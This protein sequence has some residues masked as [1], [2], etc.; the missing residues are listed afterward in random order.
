MYIY[1]YTYVYVYVCIKIFTSYSGEKITPLEAIHAL[2]HK[3][4]PSALL[5]Q[6]N[7]TDNREGTMFS[8]FKIHMYN[9]HI[10]LILL[11]LHCKIWELCVPWRIL[12]TSYVTNNICIYIIYNTHTH[13]YIYTHT[14]M[15]MKKSVQKPLFSCISVSLLKRNGFMKQCYVHRRSFVQGK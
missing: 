9:I 3:V 13:I 12:M 4:C 2:G 8:W 10:T 7:C 6:N 1:I 5:P 11:H 15:Y 14:H